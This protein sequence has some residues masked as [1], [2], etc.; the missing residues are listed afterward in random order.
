MKRKIVL[1]LLLATSLIA[2]TEL[3]I[4]LGK[5]SYDSDENLKSATTLGI[6]GDFY[7]DN[8]Y[9]IDLGYVYL[10]DNYSKDTS[11]KPSVE[12]HRFYSQFSADGEEEYHVV[13]TLSVGLGYEY[14]DGYNEDSH[15]Y[16]SLGV[17]FRYNI[18]Q[19]FN[20]LLGTKALVK[21]STRDI[22]YHTTFGM[23]YLIDEAPAN[24]ED[25]SGEEIIIPKQKLKVPEVVVPEQKIFR[26]AVVD[27]KVKSV[28]VPEV[29]DS[30]MQVASTPTVTQVT[31]PPQEEVIQ[32]E[33]TKRYVAPSSAVYIQ[34]AAFSKY[35][36]TSL[37]DRLAS[38]GNHII[39]RH[40]GS[41][42]K[43]LVGPF[44]SKEEALNALAKVKK[45][46]PRAF[47]YKGN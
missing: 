40:Q 42:T 14:Q 18:S 37:L 28:E 44:N 39:L 20:F 31:T 30:Q 46:A 1:G 43:A 26:P 38:S 45:I 33:N 5:N 15:P 25:I 8:I 4:N 34:V 36:P 47:I 11:I 24:N 21:M 19:S 2:K 29:V 16:L 32:I 23:G 12:I 10:G 6:R 17:G 7:L 9:H 35:K 41:L 13:P 3:S 27:S 22:N